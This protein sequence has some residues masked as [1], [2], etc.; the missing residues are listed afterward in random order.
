[1]PRRLPA[2]AKAKAPSGG[3]A[4]AYARLLAL[5][6]LESLA[7]DMEELGVT[8]LDDLRRRIAAL[9]SQLDAA[10]EI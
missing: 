2:T 5:E 7:E 10:D 9:H 4:E 3:D 8:S 6:R 1:M